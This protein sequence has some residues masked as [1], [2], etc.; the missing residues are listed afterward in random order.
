MLPG[1]FSI[2][3]YFFAILFLNRAHS[4]RPPVCHVTALLIR[5]SGRY[6]PV[7]AANQTMQNK[8]RASAGNRRKAVSC[9]V[10]FS[11]FPYAFYRN[12]RLHPPSSP[13]SCAQRMENASK[14]SSGSAISRNFDTTSHRFVF[15]FYRQSCPETNDYRKQHFQTGFYAFHF[16]P[17]FFPIL[18]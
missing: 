4:I 6:R 7:T 17:P 18:I 1:L 9:P 14:P 8:V 11:R 3:M 10:M 12:R 13:F 2:Y 16:G 15:T 5:R